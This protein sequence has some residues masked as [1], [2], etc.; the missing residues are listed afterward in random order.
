[1]MVVDPLSAFPSIM[2]LSCKS[3]LG[4]HRSP[5]VRLTLGFSILVVASSNLTSS[6]KVSDATEFWTGGFQ[7]DLT[8]KR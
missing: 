7:S 8:W 5:C 4:T 3:S 2:F 1:M 6:K